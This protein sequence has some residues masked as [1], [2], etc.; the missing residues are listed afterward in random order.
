MLD[1]K[2]DF[3]KLCIILLVSLVS[4]VILGLLV[5]F[6]PPLS[7]FDENIVMFWHKIALAHTNS[8]SISLL[9]TSLGSENMLYISFWVLVLFTFLKKYKEG[10]LI[11]LIVESN[12]ILST[13]TKTIFFRA[14]PPVEL[15]LYPITGYSFPSGHSL[16]SMCFYGILIYFAAIFI[17]NIYLRLTSIIL[18]SLTIISVGFSRVY[19]AVHWPSDVLGGFLLGLFWI[20][21][22]IIIY[23]RYMCKNQESQ[24]LKE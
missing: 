21:F 10:L 15:H 18:L 17:K 8:I 14:R 4:F 22:W 13:A 6:Y 1:K 24:E 3:T 2:T 11:A 23:K 12:E 9:I 7:V 20:S 19:L 5:K 16:M